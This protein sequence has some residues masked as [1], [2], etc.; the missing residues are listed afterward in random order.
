V[1]IERVC[2]IG[3]G[4]IGSL[5]AGHLG[6][7]CDVQVLTRR[8]EHAA[9]LN[10]QGLRISGKHDVL[11]RVRATSDAAALDDF[12]IGVV[13]VKANDV[14]ATAARLV[15]RC[16]GAALMTIQN[17]IGAEQVV[18]RHGDWPIISSVT[19][20][21]GIRHS[22]AHVQYELDTAT[23]MGPWAVTATPYG[24]VE[25]MAALM[26]AAGLEAEPLPD[27]LPAQWSKLIFNSAVN[28]VAALTELPHV[29]LFAREA[30]LLDL[31]HLVHGLMDEGM[32]VAA[33]AGVALHDDPW[34]MNRLAVTRGETHHGDYAHVP[35]MLE[36][37]R[38]RRPT[39]VDFITGAI[40]REAQ[41]L[42]VPAPLNAAVY[43]LVKAKEASWSL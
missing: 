26:I 4:T 5:V 7:R 38:A 6:V 23:W 27:L 9:A 39:E 11:A 32:A 2:V 13:A 33:A 34:E 17:G 8:P 15:G 1:A 31:G 16:P 24:L 43:R 42:D 22:D 14:E 21:S 28:G 3:A 41:R 20:M 29:D 36:D 37:V 30:E 40:V 12:D 25:E 10:A 35:S 19:F 18:H